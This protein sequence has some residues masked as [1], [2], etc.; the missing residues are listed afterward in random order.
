VSIAASGVFLSCQKEISC[1]DCKANKLPIAV[2]GPDRIITVPT[3]SILLDASSSND[4][5]GKIGEW[6]WKKIEGPYSF[7]IVST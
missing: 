4:P 5:D 1:E 6:L 3:D 2:A 7:N